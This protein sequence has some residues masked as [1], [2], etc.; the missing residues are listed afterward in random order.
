MI[1]KMKI[2]FWGVEKQIRNNTVSI[3]AK[4]VAM[5]LREYVQ[6]MFNLF[7][8]GVLYV[9]ELKVHVS[10]SKLKSN[11]HLTCGL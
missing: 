5:L 9:Q 1:L 3:G 7:F 4:V 6:N 2:F 11:E 8:G 10:F